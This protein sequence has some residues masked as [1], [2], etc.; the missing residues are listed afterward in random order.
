M[1]SAN[2]SIRQSANINGRKAIVI[3]AGVGGLAV[4]IRLAV[5]GYEVKV[6]ERNSGPGGKLS[7]FEKDGYIFDAGPSLFTQPRNIEELFAL[8]GEPIEE[9]FRY[10]PVSPA[11]RYFFENGKQVNAYTDKVLFADEMQRV[12]GENPE[13]VMEYLANAERAY[14]SIGHVFLDH[15]LHRSSTWLNKRLLP[16]ISATR[17]RYLT[18]SLHAYNR[19]K[20]RSVESV[21]IFDRFATYNGSNP[22]S[23][24]AMLS[25][26]P[27]LEQ[28]EG[29]FYPEGGMISIP[30][31]LYKLALKKGVQFH[32]NTPAGKIIHKDGRVCGIMAAGERI[33]ADSVISNIDVYYAYRDLLDDAVRAKKVLTRERSSSALIFYWGIKREFPKLHLHNIF[34]S[35]NYR[36]EFR[37]LFDLKKLY[38]DPTIYINI[39]SKMEKGHTPGGT[40]N[41]FVMLNAP[42]NAGQDW[43]EIRLQARENIIEKLTRMTGEDIS[44]SIETEIVLDPRGIEANTLS[45][46]GS[47]YGT[48]SNSPWAA[49]LRHPNFAGHIKGLYFTG[50]SVHPGGGIPLCLKSAK[51]VADLC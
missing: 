36:E 15:S 42:A 51:I 5:K 32:F 22:Y 10:K 47:L 33:D 44:S 8:A 9:Y 17:W 46:M 27:H 26:I 12:L 11:C 39:T 3:G 48:S 31:A 25:M 2:P 7:I 34:F 21:Q 35:N 29:T 16:A 23:A 18:N 38:M 24:P 41:W 14:K 45:H 28:N 40:E 37:H 20:F 13:A 43:N 50:G 49:F 4:A 6:F 30:S 19:E 1:Q